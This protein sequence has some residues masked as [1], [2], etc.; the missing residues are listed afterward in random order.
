MLEKTQEYA[1]DLA[2]KVTQRLLDKQILETNSNQAIQESLE[3]Q[4][5]NLINMDEFDVQ[6][7]IAPLRTITQDPNFVSLYITQYVIEDLIDH[8][9][10]QDI[11]GDDLAVYQAIDSVLN[12]LRPR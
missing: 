5:H 1:A 7:K 12:V 10:V 11:F 8:P 9:N 4:L 2:I 3:K 6:F